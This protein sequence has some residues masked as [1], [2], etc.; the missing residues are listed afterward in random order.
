MTRSRKVKCDAR[1]PLVREF[2][3]LVNESDRSVSDIA[4]EVGTYSQTI[5]G[6][7][8]PKHYAPKI[9][10]LEAAFNVMGYKLVLAPLTEP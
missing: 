9:D 2:F 10:T 6:W 8:G 4:A 7:A 3:R 1:I 5:F